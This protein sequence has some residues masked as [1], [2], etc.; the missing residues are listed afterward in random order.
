MAEVPEVCLCG[1]KRTGLC[2]GRIWFKCGSWCR[3]IGTKWRGHRTIACVEA[4]S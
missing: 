4:R 2:D 3:W 1:A